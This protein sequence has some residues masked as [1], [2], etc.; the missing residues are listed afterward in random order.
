MKKGT[1]HTT[2]PKH[3]IRPTEPEKPTNTQIRLALYLKGALNLE[4]YNNNHTLNP[5]YTE[6]M[7]D[8]IRFTTMESAINLEKKIKL[9]GNEILLIEPCNGTHYE[10]RYKPAEYISALLDLGERLLENKANHP[11]CERIKMILKNLLD[12]FGFIGPGFVDPKHFETNL[13]EFFAKKI[14]ITRAVTKI[15]SKDLIIDSKTFNAILLGKTVEKAD[16]KILNAIRK[17]RENM[18]LKGIENEKNVSAILEKEK[19]RIELAK[20][21]DI[22]S[23]FKESDFYSTKSTQEQIRE[24]SDKLSGKIDPEKIRDILNGNITE[25]PEEL[26]TFISKAKEVYQRL[27]EKLKT[28]LYNSIYSVLSRIANGQKIF[29]INC[30]AT[31]HYESGILC[32]PLEIKSST[33]DDKIQQFHYS[34]AKST[35][36]LSL[37]YDNAFRDVILRNKRIVIGDTLKIS[38]NS[39]KNGLLAWDERN[40]IFQIGI[41]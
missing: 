28:E 19:T 30:F 8:E 15:Y 3:F 27:D 33:I 21:L 26:T 17:K 11:I 34:T 37:V 7:L 36:F 13:D 4:S 14:I 39:K 10:F 35:F 12:H 18:D 20:V 1:I 2:E 16:S 31:Y 40:N 38:L 23:G 6:S 22:N 25:I 41:N 9:Y 32:V 24:L 5:R 29:S